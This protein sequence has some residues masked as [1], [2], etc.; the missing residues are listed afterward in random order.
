MWVP[1]CVKKVLPVWSLLMGI[2]EG[3]IE[4]RPNMGIICTNCS[5]DNVK[6]NCVCETKICLHFELLALYH[7]IYF[8]SEWIRIGAGLAIGI[9]KMHNCF[10]LFICCDR[11][12]KR[13]Y[14]GIYDRLFNFCFLSLKELL[15][16]MCDTE[17]N[18]RWVWCYTDYGISYVNGLF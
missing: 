7:D 1:H 14:N 5:T 18:D 16:N 3:K 6:V 15:Q 17:L 2:W 12:H 4:F 11:T 13:F 10:S 9:I 8:D